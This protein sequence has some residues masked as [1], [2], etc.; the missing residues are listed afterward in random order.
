MRWCRTARRRIAPQRAPNSEWSAWQNAMVVSA[1]AA[2]QYKAM[3]TRSCTRLGI[4]YSRLVARPNV[5]VK[6][7]PAA[8]RQAR[9]GENV[10]VPPARAWWLAVGPRLERGVRPQRSFQPAHL[11]FCFR[12]PGPPFEPQPPPPVPPLWP[13]PPPLRPPPP[14]WRPRASEMDGRIK[15]VPD[16]AL[17][18]F[19]RFMILFITGTTAA[20][21]ASLI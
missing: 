9:A 4:S 5:R 18:K 6:A 10:R 11:P 20:R 12:Y 3:P 15:T 17:M 13:D 7:G 16:T 21:I 8:R 2:R 1:V 14:P 19:L